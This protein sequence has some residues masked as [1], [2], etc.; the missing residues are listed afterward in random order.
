MRKVSWGNHCAIGR[1]RSPEAM[2]RRK[3][4]ER[5]LRLKDKE[6]TAALRA[7]GVLAP[8]YS[9]APPDH[10][11]E[12]ARFAIAAGPRDI[13][14]AAFGDPLPGRSALDRRA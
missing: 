10:V 1:T 7:S 4:R 13:T 11:L 8:A 12:E 9:R 14:A 6:A 2:A 5:A 3:E